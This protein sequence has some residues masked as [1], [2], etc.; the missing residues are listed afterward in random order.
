MNDLL[1]NTSPYR[2][3]ARRRMLRLPWLICALLATALLGEDRAGAQEIWDYS[4]YEIEV[5]VSFDRSPEFTPRFQEEFSADLQDRCLAIIGSPWN[6]RFGPPVASLATDCAADMELVTADRIEAA[7]RPSEKK[8]SKLLEGDKM[9]LLSVTS[10]SIGYTV[11][12]RE[13]DCR[14]RRWGPIIRRTVRQKE[15]IL[16]SAMEA[17][18]KAFLPLVRLVEV[19]EEKVE[20]G[21]GED[22][23][24]K[25]TDIAKV[26]VRAGGLI[27]GDTHPAL[28]RVDTVMLPVIRRNNRLGKPQEIAA[29]PWTYIVI[30]QRQRSILYGE[31]ISGMRSPLGGRSGRRTLRLAL[32]M[33]MT[34]TK[35][36]LIIKNKV[37]SK[38][39]EQHPLPGYEIYEKNLQT[40]R[41]ELLGTTDWRGALSIEQQDRPLRLIYVKSGSRLLARL[42]IVPGV[43]EFVVAEINEDLLRL[44][45]ESVI[46]SFQAR[47]MDLVAKRQV[48]ATQTRRRIEQGRL[49]DAETMVGQLRKLDTLNQ[50]VIE[51]NQH[52]KTYTS[53]DP[54][55]R[56]RIEP[57]FDE[58]RNLLY[59]FLTGDMSAVLNREIAAAKAKS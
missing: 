51:L 21:S 29:V 55:L 39:E 57:M 42:P 31:V 50:M 8:P 54:R 56:S 35:T 15:L 28:P 6:A 58:T 33:P 49:E 22:T 13:L 11:A 4:P 12:A 3:S 5:W 27:L 48:I 53:S 17:I 10:D 43:E 16:Y 38:D 47:M 40:D 2:L 14:T 34:G 23:R 44:E 19:V 30:R 7:T 52:Q 9:M 18:G 45:A 24:I 25:K 37:S 32:A 20:V 41:S 59:K 26:E 36:D 46:R 1:T